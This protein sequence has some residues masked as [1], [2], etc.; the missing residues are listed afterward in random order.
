[1]FQSLLWW[2]GCV[3]MH[4][5]GLQ[6]GADVVSIL[7]VVDWLRQPAPRPPARRRRGFNPCCGGLAASTGLGQPPEPHDH[8]V[9]ILVVV[10]WLRQPSAVRGPAVRK[11]CFNP[12]CGGL[13]AST[14]GISS[15]PL[16]AAN[17]SI[18]VVVDWLRQHRDNV[19]VQAEVTGFQS[20]LW[21]IGCVNQ[22]KNDE[23]AGIIAFQSLLWWI[24]CVNPAGRNRP[25]DPGTVSILVVV[26][27]LRQPRR[28]P[29][30]TNRR[31]CFNPCCGGLAASTGEFTPLQMVVIPFQSLLWWIGCVNRVVPVR[32]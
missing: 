5:N 27:W 15:V 19:K 14:T 7:V 3:N 32:H 20:L 22:S 23:A 26:D 6:H 13:A 29:W 21:W 1:M 16:I 18:L 11:D 28:R 9:S 4:V 30:T 8:E 24:G 25:K 2:I 12:C 10:D 17:V 31:T